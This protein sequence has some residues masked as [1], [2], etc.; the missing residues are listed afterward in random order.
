MPEFRDILIIKAEPRIEVL[1]ATCLLRPLAA[2]YPGER[3]IWV[4]GK[5]C[6]AL[7]QGNHY[8]SELYFYEEGG[9][10]AAALNRRFQAVISLEKGNGMGDAANLLQAEAK[11]GLYRNA[12]GELLAFNAGAEQLKLWAA[13]GGKAAELNETSYQE[14]LAAAV[15]IPEASASEMVFHPPENSR[16]F[17]EIWREERKITGKPLVGIYLGNDPRNAAHSPDIRSVSFL[18][19]KVLQELKSEVVI[20][21]GKMEERL[22]FDCMN[23]CPPGTVDGGCFS[24][25]AQMAGIIGMCDTLIGTDSLGVQLAI[26]MGKKVVVLQETLRKA[27]SYGRG[28]TVQCESKADIKTGRKVLRF[29]PEK[30]LTAVKELIREAE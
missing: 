20:F 26:A 17:G 8:V 19:E 10:L 14:T 30:V 23:S 12:L 16:Q 25:F 9:Y 7:L 13:S 5:R 18:A 4:T 22:L 27:E 15:E 29:D 2:K 6:Q 24:A 3:V 28:R 1:Q 11:F 21:A